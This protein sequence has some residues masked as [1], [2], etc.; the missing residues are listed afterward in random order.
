MLCSDRLVRRSQPPRCCG[1]SWAATKRPRPRAGLQR[2][3]LRVPCAASAGGA[4][5][6]AEAPAQCGSE[7]GSVSVGHKVRA[8]SAL[9]RRVCFSASLRSSSSDHRANARVCR[10]VSTRPPADSYTAQRT[11]QQHAA[12][13]KAAKNVMHGRAS[14]T[15][16]ESAGTSR[17]CRVVAKCDRPERGSAC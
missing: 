16:C 2:V 6:Q 7:P 3:R 14:A 13:L 10:C 8:Q 11:V 17:A 9:S 4:E 1:P 15:A 5:A 12:S